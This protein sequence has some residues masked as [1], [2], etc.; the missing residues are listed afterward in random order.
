MAC[1]V[2]YLY[3]NIRY[4]L[5][6]VDGEHYIVDLG[7]SF[8]K[9][10]FPLAF[11]MLPHT[12]FKVQDRTMVETFQM[13]DGEQTK[14]SPLN[15]FAVGITLILANLLGPLMDYLNISTSR[16]ANIAI[17][18]SIVLI[19]ILQRYWF[20]KQ[21]KNNLYRHINLTQCETRRVWVRPKSFMYGLKYL[22]T[23]LVFVA[24]GL[25]FILGFIE[26]GNVMWLLG[27]ILL[28]YCL[29]ICSGFT[30]GEGK[31][32]LKFVNDH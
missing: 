24:L 6:S 18:L 10:L 30:I 7:K 13:S 8:W 14:M 4:R 17:L 32:T 5:I 19:I 15:F 23:Y 21:N 2:H 1:E 9:I 16:N 22:F 26:I 12:A 11:W 20:T 25:I 3:K 31:T 28:L 29:V 27:I